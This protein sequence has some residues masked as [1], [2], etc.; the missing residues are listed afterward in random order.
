[1]C[2]KIFTQINFFRIF[3]NKSITI[4]TS[5]ILTKKFKCCF[6]R[7]F[8]RVTTHTLYKKATFS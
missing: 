1:M 3:F 7:D 5:F 6:R 8:I 4:K 2:K